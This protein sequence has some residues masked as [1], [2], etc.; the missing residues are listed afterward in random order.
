[1]PRLRWGLLP[2]LL[3]MAPTAWA[4]TASSAGGVCE[5]T[6]DE[7]PTPT[8]PMQYYLYA[9]REGESYRFAVRQPSGGRPVASAENQVGKVAQHVPCARVVLAGDGRYFLVVTAVALD[10]SEESEPSNEL[11]LDVRGGRLVAWGVVEGEAPIPEPP[12]VPKPP[13]VPKPPA[14]GQPQVK[15][16]KPPPPLAVM[17]PIPPPMSSG[18]ASLSESC[19]WNSCQRSALPRTVPP[20]FGQGSPGLEDSAI[21]NGR[22]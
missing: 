12:P 4:F 5:L 10:L 18:G 2:V 3:L 11:W 21:W 14:A 8:V 15:D 6:W 17:R 22:R 1:M 20:G 19:I 13:T 9:R 7:S 16:G